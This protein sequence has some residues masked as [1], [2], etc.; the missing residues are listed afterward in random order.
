MEQNSTQKLNSW[1]W[2]L[3]FQKLLNL[4]VHT[5]FVTYE[6]RHLRKRTKLLIEWL[7]VQFLSAAIFP[8]T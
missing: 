3:D 5:R 6:T 1:A 2:E 8:P 4:Q 7:K